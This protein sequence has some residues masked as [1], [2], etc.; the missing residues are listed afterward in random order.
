MSFRSTFLGDIAGQITKA[1]A[2]ADRV[3]V[4]A[5]LLPSGAERHVRKRIGGTPKWRNA[6]DA[7]VKH[8]VRILREESLSICGGSVDKNTN[9]WSE[10]W[11][12]A[13]AVHTKAASIE[14]ASIGFLKAA[15]LVKFLLFSHAS[16][17]CLGHAVYCGAIPAAVRRRGRIIVTES[18]ILDNEIHG[19]DN[20]DALIE[21]IRS[22]NSHRPLA[23]SAG[24]D[25]RI[26]LLR[27]ASEQSEPLLLLADY[28][29]GIAHAHHSKS[30]VLLR[31]AISEECAA[32]AYS[33]LNS[34][35][36]YVD[37]SGTVRLD[38]FSIYPDFRSL[39][40]RGAPRT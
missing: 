28:I 32:E 35:Y 19:E 8:V 15:T 18:M 9:E 16:A 31:S 29:A 6:S 21:I 20:R 27:L 17:T 12:N 7:D 24:L 33:A 5:V 2:N 10:F 14:R 40:V 38:Y 30:N 11:S 23:L 25:R 37:I 1:S 34:A 26:G 22:T 4:G 3:T 36:G 13:E 39:V